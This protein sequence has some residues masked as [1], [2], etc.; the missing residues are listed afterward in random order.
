[1]PAKRKLTQMQD[2]ALILAITAVAAKK[3]G[4]SNGVSQTG[5]SAKR[6]RLDSQVD[7]SDVDAQPRAS[8]SATVTV[9]PKANDILAQLT[10]GRNENEQVPGQIDEGNY[11]GSITEGGQDEEQGDMDD[12]A[13]S[14]LSQLFANNSNANITSEFDDDYDGSFMGGD[15]DSSKILIENINALFNSQ[16]SQE[17]FSPGGKNAKKQSRAGRQINCVS[18]KRVLGECSRCQKP[19]TAGARQMHMFYHLAKDQDTYRF[20]CLFDNC[21]VQH[22]RKDQMENHQSKMH[23]RIDP[24]MMEDRSAQLHDTVQLLSME[25]LGTSGNQPGPT[26]ERAQIVYNNMQREAAEATGKKK[27]RIGF[28]RSEFNGDGASSPSTSNVSSP[29]GNRYGG[30]L[31]SNFV[32]PEQHRN[33]DFIK[34][35][36]CQKTILGRTR[37]FH[38]LWHLNNDLNIVRYH[39]RL[40]DFKHDRSQSINNHGKREHG[41]ENCCVDTIGVSLVSASGNGY[42]FPLSVHSHVNYLSAFRIMTRRSVPCQRPASESNSSLLRIQ[43]ATRRTSRKTTPSPLSWKICSLL[44]RTLKARSWMRMNKSARLTVTLLTNKR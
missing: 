17:A 6:P 41:D 40:C 25:L 26:A 20:K 7:N 1:M 32:K 13:A 10:A 44:G 22:Y 11:N 39:C 34:C 5:T 4:S 43:P 33:E 35:M 42:P 38:L 14:Q 18:K 12:F 29:H 37:G 15:N 31:D 16:P 19:V 36:L 8:A 2:K 23:G 9:L 27:R 28:V 24:E 21:D 3:G 30:E